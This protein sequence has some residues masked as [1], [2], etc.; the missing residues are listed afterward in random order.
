MLIIDTTIYLIPY[1][2][3]DHLQN[4][5]NNNF[6][7][8][9]MHQITIITSFAFKWKHNKI[10]YV[11]WW[12]EHLLFSAQVWKII[13][14]SIN[15]F[16]IRNTKKC[17]GQTR[18]TETCF[19]SIVCTICQ[20]CSYIHLTWVAGQDSARAYKINEQNKFINFSYGIIIAKKFAVVQFHFWNSV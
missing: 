4:E 5:F 8:S 6:T 7:K 14:V 2:F 16:G 17:I 20:L 10:Q 9:L 1:Y 11:C 12:F 15:R 13:H 18:K 3:T 19:I